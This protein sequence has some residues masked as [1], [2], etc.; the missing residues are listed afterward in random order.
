M[1]QLNHYKFEKEILENYQGWQ[2][3]RC[4]D[5]FDDGS[6]EGTVNIRHQK[7][8]TP[9]NSTV[10]LKN[11]EITPQELQDFRNLIDKSNEFN[12]NIEVSQSEANEVFDVFK[13]E[14]W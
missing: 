5:K 13:S 6:F 1:N 14:V 11:R 2:I 9:K 10:F 4:L 8:A 3:I 12:F 7:Y